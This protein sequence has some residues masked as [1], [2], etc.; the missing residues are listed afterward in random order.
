MPT[1]ITHTAVALA[2]GKAFAPSVPKR[3]WLLSVACA[4]LPDADVIGFAL[5]IPYHH[6]LGHRGFFHSP[7]FSLLLSLFIV[8]AFFRS[9]K[10]FSRQ[11]F[12]YF[13][14]FFLLSA[15]H[16]LLDAFT[17]GGLGIA[18]FSPFDNTRYFFPWTPIAVSPISIHRFLSPWGLEVI[19]SE[20]RWVWTPLLVMVVLSALVRIPLSISK[21]PA[22]NKPA[23][24]QSN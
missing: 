2:A 10:I 19:K 18:L 16:G 4:V 1:I 9:V 3:F 14:F 24:P 13:T 11:W 23:D 5:G 21:Q 15:S 20:I 17:N 6:F 8:G 7:F 22:N 12:F